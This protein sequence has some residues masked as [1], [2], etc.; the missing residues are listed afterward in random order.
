MW[1]TAAEACTF[2]YEE[3]ADRLN[4]DVRLGLTWQ[5]ATHRRQIVGYV[6]VKYFFKNLVLW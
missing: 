3:V 4:V 5:E 1:I 2:G 6:I